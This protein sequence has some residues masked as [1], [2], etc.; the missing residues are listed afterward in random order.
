MFKLGK[1]EGLSSD[2]KQAIVALV[3]QNT[4]MRNLHRRKLEKIIAEDSEPFNENEDSNQQGPKFLLNDLEEISTIQNDPQFYVEKYVLQAVRE[5]NEEEAAIRSSRI[6]PNNGSASVPHTPEIHLRNFTELS[7]RE[8]Y[9]T[10]VDRNTHVRHVE[11]DHQ[12]TLAYQQISKVTHAL[13]DWVRENL[14]TE[15]KLVDPLAPKPKSPPKDSKES[16][17]ISVEGNESLTL[18]PISN[19]SNNDTWKNN[20]K[21]YIN[22]IDHSNNKVHSGPGHF[23]ILYNACKPSILETKPLMKFKISIE[24]DA[25]PAVLN[26][27]KKNFGLNIDSIKLSLQKHNRKRKNKFSLIFIHWLIL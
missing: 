13:D 16:H 17:S 14:D 2:Q 9:K 26:S 1:F 19:V 24:H 3:E 21:F 11:E 4:K 20:Y 8:K 12:A 22:Y 27:L 23:D 18:P 7:P 6:K 15:V 5:K 10:F 25:P